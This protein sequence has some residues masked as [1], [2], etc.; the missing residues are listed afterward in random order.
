MSTSKDDILE[1]SFAPEITDHEKKA[2]RIKSICRRQVDNKACINRL[3]RSSFSGPG[4]IGRLSKAFKAGNVGPTKSISEVSSFSKSVC[5][6]NK[7]S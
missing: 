6:Q 1:K 5:M 7:I 4:A 3:Y 2:H